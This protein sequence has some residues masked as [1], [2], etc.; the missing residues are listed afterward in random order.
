MPRELGE[1]RHVLVLTN[2]G[3][4]PV[5][6]GRDE[7]V[8]GPRMTDAKGNVG[9]TFSTLTRVGLRPVEHPWLCQGGRHTTHAR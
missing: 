3:Y 7:E 2:E 4:A 5:S 6:S 1:L 8:S 9:P